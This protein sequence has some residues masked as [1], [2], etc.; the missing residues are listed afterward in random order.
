MRRILLSLVLLVEVVGLRPRSDAFS[1]LGEPP[2][3]F[4]DQTGRETPGDVYGPVN[5]GE[6]YRWVVPQI[7]YAFDQSFLDYFGQDGVD[8]VEEAIQIFNSVPAVS[9]V[10]LPDYPLH[11]QRVNY[12]ARDLAMLDLKSFAMRALAEQ[13]GL[14]TPSR[15]SFT[16]RLRDTPPGATNYLVMMRNFDPETWEPSPY[17]NG[18]LWTYLDMYENQDDPVVKAS[19]IPEPVDP[20]IL[21]EP[22]AS[23]ETGFAATVFGLGSFYTGLTQ[24]DVGGLRYIYRS[25]N[26][27]VETLPLDA[28]GGGFAIGG[29]GEPWWPVGLPSTNVA[30]GGAT[31][32][33][34]FFPQALRGGSDRV[35]FVRPVGGVFQP[36][37]YGATN[38]F[39]EQVIAV[40]TNGVQS[41]VDQTVVRF[42]TAPDIVFAAEDLVS[43]A[44]PIQFSLMARTEAATSNDLI[45]GQPTLTPQDGPGQ[46]AGPVVIAFTKFGRAFFNS[47][48]NFLSQPP[49]SFPFWGSF[50]GSTNAPIPYPTGTSIQEIESLIFGGR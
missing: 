10:Q 27:N 35:Q 47:Q 39:S 14:G 3:W 21:A 25:G 37:G 34:P 41:E 22:V 20:L 24:D 11:S 9:Q 1:L 8:A 49:S 29:G 5:L 42:L 26:R 40:I 2:N 46:I 7:V 13:L 23:L 16:I 50:D 32:V 6:E 4:T 19:T 48:P 44:P 43:D 15:F 30:G 17:V 38:V 12:R 18:Q 36:N 33:I 28:T 45:N 31:N